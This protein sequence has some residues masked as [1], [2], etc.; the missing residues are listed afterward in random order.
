MLAAFLEVKTKAEAQKNSPK[1]KGKKKKSSLAASNSGTYMQNYWAHGSLREA[2]VP[3]KTLKFK[4]K[5]E[6]DKIR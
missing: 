1:K 4:T 3:W 6:D 5:S 2:N